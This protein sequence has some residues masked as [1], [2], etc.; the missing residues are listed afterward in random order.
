MNL[1]Y[2]NTSLKIHICPALLLTNHPCL[3]LDVFYGSHIE[4]KNHFGSMFS[5]P[6][7]SA[8]VYSLEEVFHSVHNACRG[9]LVKVSKQQ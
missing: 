4:F 9:L 3:D 6:L 1:H 7:Q 5:I 2:K 8:H